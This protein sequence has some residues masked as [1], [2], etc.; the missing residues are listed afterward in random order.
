ML[1]RFSHASR[2][3]ISAVRS[4]PAWK[5]APACASALH[6]SLPCRSFTSTHLPNQ[7]ELN[8][9]DIAVL[10][11]K[12]T[13]FSNL[14]LPRGSNGSDEALDTYDGGDEVLSTS[15]SRDNASMVTFQD[16]RV[17]EILKSKSKFGTSIHTV[18]AD[19]RCVVAL[20]KMSYL[21]IG[22][23]LVESDTKRGEI[24]GI[25]ST[26]D[27]ARGVSEKKIDVAN[28]KVRD[29][30]THSPVHIYSDESSLSA[31]NIMTTHGFRHMPVRDRKTNAVV[32][33][34]SIGD[35]V[36]VIL[37]QAQTSNAHLRDFIDGKYPA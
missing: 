10:K 23:V 3:V 22:V 32:G 1:S 31:M 24:V 9:H 34:I 8:S 5:L 7:Q 6:R 2:R 4:R 12:V 20:E 27:Y 15:S 19:D 25:M 29:F 13:P 21:S 18:R 30:M 14:N 28:A 33:L 37:Q 16:T 17:D 35:L 11:H 26:R 36:R